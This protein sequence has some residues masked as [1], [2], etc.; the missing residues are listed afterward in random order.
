[1]VGGD[2]RIRIKAEVDSMLRIYIENN[3]IP[4][5]NNGNDSVSIGQGIALHNAMLAVFGGGMRLESTG[6]GNILVTISLPLSVG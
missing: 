3:G 2:L 6:S 1:L 4:E 5:E